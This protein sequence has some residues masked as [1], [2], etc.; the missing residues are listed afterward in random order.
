MDKTVSYRSLGAVWGNYWG[1]GQGGFRARPIEGCHSL[2]EL[3]EKA[4]AMLKDGSLDAGMGYE[5][6]IGARLVVTKTE[7]VLL[8]GKKFT[9]EETFPLVVGYLS[10]GVQ[11]HLESL[12]L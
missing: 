6:L 9:H 12:F 11:E 3:K 7:T 5:S 4:E 2:E 10:Q 8:K 1:G